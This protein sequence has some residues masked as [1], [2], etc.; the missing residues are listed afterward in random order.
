[1]KK[2]YALYLDRLNEPMEKMIMGMCPEEVDLRFLQPVI[3]PKGELEDAD[4]LID[5]TFK[6]T[7]EIIDKAQNLKLIQRTGTG[8]D[9]VDM[10]YAREKDIPVSICKGF[11][12]DSVAD[13]ALMGMLALYRKLT[14]LN[15]STQKGKWDTWKYRH[16]SYELNDK[17]IGIVGAG[18]IGKKVAKRVQAFGAKT[19]YYDAFRLPK[20]TEEELNLEYVDFETLIRTSDVITLHVPLTAETKGIIGKEAFEMMKDTAI[21]INTARETLVNLEVLK[22]VLAKGKIQGA[23]LDIFS[24]LQEQNPLFGINCENLIL[25][26]HIGA[27]TYDNYYKCYSLCMRNA[28]HMVRGEELEYVI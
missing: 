4:I 7:R 23:F 26:P 28:L 24:P 10:E 12:A 9:M 25:T 14:A 5:T 2:V 22:D 21:L 19:I 11:N 6:V 13:L 16:V 27:A 15:E 8:V 3:G 1:M 18:M 17:T 20:E